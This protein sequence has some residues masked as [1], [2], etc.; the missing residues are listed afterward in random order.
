M[1][2]DAQHDRMEALAENQKPDDQ[3]RRQSTADP[4][5]HL[6][7]L[8]GAPQ[9]Q[10][11]DRRNSFGNPDGFNLTSGSFMGLLRGF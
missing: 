4:A 1:N 3:Q 5:R 7:I 2:V 10:E 6:R 8:P 11:K 9:Q